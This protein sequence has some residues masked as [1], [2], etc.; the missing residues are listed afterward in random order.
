MSI[1]IPILAMAVG[2][3]CIV[4]Y[5]FGFRSG[6]K[7]S[8]HKEDQQG[9][10]VLTLA[11]YKAAES[12]NWPKVKSLLRVELLGFTREYER[13][14]GVPVGTNIYTKKFQEAKTIADRIE[15]E[16]VPVSSL[17]AILGSNVTV[18]IKKEP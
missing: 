11:G 1:K 18:R 16:M 3:A 7:Q 17:G 2:I 6:I 13:R 9:L 14:F 8:R 5:L 12:N 4:C 15:K 10:V